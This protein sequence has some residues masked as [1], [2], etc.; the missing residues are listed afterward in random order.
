MGICELQNDI[1]KNLASDNHLITWFDLE[2]KKRKR[3][4]VLS[5]Y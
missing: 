2:K 1:P 3:E 4:S 5:Q